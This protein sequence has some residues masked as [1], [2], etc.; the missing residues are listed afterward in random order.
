[1]TSQ[2]K[3]AIFTYPC[4]HLPHAQ[5][6]NEVQDDEATK[7]IF[8]V[9]EAHPHYAELFK[10][11]VKLEEVKQGYTDRS[12]ELAKQIAIQAGWVE[13][14]K[15]G[16]Y[17]YLS[18]ILG[19][20]S[21]EQMVEKDSVVDTGLLQIEPMPKPNGAY[22]AT[23]LAEAR[24]M[25]YQAEAIRIRLEMDVAGYNANS[26]RKE[27]QDRITALETQLASLSSTVVALS[28][29]AHDS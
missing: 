3:I 29:E 15:A 6:L 27:M 23:E 9:D 10:E 13:S 16:V 11:T 7:I 22:S 21:S 12:Q 26:P 28:K 17:Q 1:M 2:R 5:F 4:C 20:N 19:G 14:G 25:H 24:L 8:V 18:S